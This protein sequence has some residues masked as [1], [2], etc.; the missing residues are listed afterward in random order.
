[1]IVM[2]PSVIAALSVKD[3]LAVSETEHWGKIIKYFLHKSCGKKNNIRNTKITHARYQK[4]LAFA[5]KQP[6]LHTFVSFSCIYTSNCNT[7]YPISQVA[8]SCRIV[9]QLYS[10]SVV[11]PEKIRLID[12]NR[13]RQGHTIFKI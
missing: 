3:G 6:H 13:H 9:S 11:D 8:N 4:V 10:K 5:L 12:T 1:M 7:F 2:F